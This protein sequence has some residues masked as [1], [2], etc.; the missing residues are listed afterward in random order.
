M[1]DAARSPARQRSNSDVRVNE[2]DI[3][4][5]SRKDQ[6]HDFPFRKARFPKGDDSPDDS[7]GGD[8]ED[9]AVAA[10]GCGF[11]DGVDDVEDY[12]DD[13]GKELENAEGLEELGRD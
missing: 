6:N 11:A 4:Y 1:F 12:G 9:G 5:H 13:G 8:A 7:A 3:K 10:G 2:R